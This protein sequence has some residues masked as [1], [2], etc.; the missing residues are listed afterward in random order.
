MCVPFYPHHTAALFWL[1]RLCPVHRRSIC[2]FSIILFFR[3][4]DLLIHFLFQHFPPL[5]PGEGFPAC[6]WP[7]CYPASKSFW[8]VESEKGE[9]F[10]PFLKLPSTVVLYACTLHTHSHFCHRLLL[11][12][13]VV[14]LFLLV[15]SGGGLKGL[16]NRT[17]ECASRRNWK[18]SPFPFWQRRAV[19]SIN[20]HFCQISSNRGRFPQI[21][22]DA[23]E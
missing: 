7:R 18:I 12:V 19:R 23:V 3:G 21:H 22:L 6:L 4:S 16:N 8:K 2:S 11:P 17:G 14:L 15:A 20:N 9:N 5:D 10:F 13:S 1:D